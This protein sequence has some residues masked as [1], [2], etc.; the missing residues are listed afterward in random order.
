[1]NPHD[2]EEV[3]RPYL[4][5]VYTADEA[6]MQTGTRTPIMQI[7]DALEAHERALRVALDKAL[8]L[9]EVQS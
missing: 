7:L 1:M 9:L 6:V 8:E 2:A 4:E 5:A 3:L